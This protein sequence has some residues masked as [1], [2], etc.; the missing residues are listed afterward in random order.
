MTDKEAQTDLRRG[1]AVEIKTRQA[2][3]T[4]ES[5]HNS[6]R[7][8]AKRLG[9]I[10]LRKEVSRVGVIDV[11]LF[12]RKLPQGCGNGRQSVRVRANVF[13]TR[14]KISSNRPNDCTWMCRLGRSE[15]GCRRVAVV[16][17]RP[18]PPKRSSA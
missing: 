1:K 2:V 15:A 11:A 5:Q 12:E 3:N 4:G 16:N 14:Y 13:S 6:K 18:Y 10:A 9:A 7:D 17:W 8:A